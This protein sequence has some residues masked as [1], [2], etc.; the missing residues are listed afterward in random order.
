VLLQGPLIRR[1]IAGGK[2][3]VDHR[4]HAPLS[5]SRNDASSLPA[6]SF[7]RSDGKPTGGRSG[8]YELSK[9]YNCNAMKSFIHQYGQ[10]Y[11]NFW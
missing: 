7:G 1:K 9:N 3:L 6:S 11:L 8:A 5:A 4:S 10:E 2:A